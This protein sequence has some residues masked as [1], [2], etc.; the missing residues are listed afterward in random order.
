M[1]S[2]PSRGNQPNFFGRVFR[3][4]K[5]M[6]WFFSNFVVVL[7]NSSSKCEFINLKKL[8]HVIIKPLVVS[9]WRVAL[10]LGGFFRLCR[11][12]F[13]FERIYFD[14]TF[15]SE[16][17]EKLSH[18][19]QSFPTYFVQ[20]FPM[21]NFFRKYNIKY[22]RCTLIC[23]KTSK[24]D[25][26]DRG[27]KIGFRSRCKHAENMHDISTRSCTRTLT[28]IELTLQYVVKHYLLSP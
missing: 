6:L 1:C 14:P 10:A 11:S 8:V 5:K 20:K 9:V 15:F 4:E 22:S 7:F 19:L 2:S 23:E 12:E 18:S 24:V 26:V 21:V 3:K 25:I 16:M 13:H 27:P 17:L 28:R